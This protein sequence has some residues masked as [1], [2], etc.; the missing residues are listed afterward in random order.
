VL[1]R[2]GGLSLDLVDPA[3]FGGPG[4]QLLAGGGGMKG[5]VPSEPKFFRVL[6]GAGCLALRPRVGAASVVNG[7]GCGMLALPPKVEAQ[8]RSEA[9]GSGV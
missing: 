1:L 6:S 3:Q 9:L 4:H 8:H 7:F 2:N 5:W